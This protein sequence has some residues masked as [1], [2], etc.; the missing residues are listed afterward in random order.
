LYKEVAVHGHSI[1]VTNKHHKDLLK[2]FISVTPRAMS[3]DK[4]YRRI[5]NRSTEPDVDVEV[6]DDFRK[7]NLT[8]FF[9]TW[10]NQIDNLHRITFDDVLRDFWSM[11]NSHLI[12]FW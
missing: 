11:Y 10:L 6:T 8:D 5:F 1:L 4:L 2:F 9:G 7:A 3:S 12:D